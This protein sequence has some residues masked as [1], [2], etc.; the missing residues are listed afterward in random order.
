MF[1]VIRDKLRNSLI[2]SNRI[3]LRQQG[4]N[5]L[6]DLVSL[7]DRFMGDGD[8]M[9]YG[10]E[11]DDF[12]SWSNP[13]APIEAIRQRLLEFEALLFGSPKD[14]AKYGE[15]LLAEREKLIAQLGRQDKQGPT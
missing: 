2:Q 10:L 12:I 14:R 4:V 3:H 13:N 11:W 1:R 6:R 8:Q 9:Q 7:I 15:L 5:S